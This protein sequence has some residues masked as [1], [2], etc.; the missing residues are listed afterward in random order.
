[1]ILFTALDPANHHLIIGRGTDERSAADDLLARIADYAATHPQA[2]PSDAWRI[3]FE[4][5]ENWS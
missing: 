5:A 3:N 1:M 4:P 2:M